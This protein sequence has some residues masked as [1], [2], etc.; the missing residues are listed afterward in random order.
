M[1]KLKDVVFSVLNDYGNQQI[2]DGTKIDLMNKIS[3]RWRN[4]VSES[5][6]KVK[7]QKIVSTL[8]NRLGI[9]VEVE[10]DTTKTLNNSFRSM[11]LD[12]LNGYVGK[13]LD[14]VTKIDIA[15]ELEKKWIDEVKKIAKGALIAKATEESNRRNYIING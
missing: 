7:S 11:I 5:Q 14:E 9:H 15:S 4:F 10:K 1:G 8:E 13:E 12:V 3:E 6:T 2:N